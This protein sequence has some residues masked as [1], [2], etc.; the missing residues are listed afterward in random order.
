L[1]RE[2]ADQEFKDFQKVIEE[3]TPKVFKE[4]LFNRKVFNKLYGSVVTRCF[5]YGVP[6]T[7]LLPVADGMNHYDKEGVSYEIINKSLHLKLGEETS[8]YSQKKYMNNYELL[9][10]KED[11]FD[12]SSEITGGIFDKEKY[13][14]V[15]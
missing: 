8:Y 1:F 10:P 2:T 11:M 15:E 13:E 7:C 4:D 14:Q 6:S 3:N 9:F 12:Y 5:G